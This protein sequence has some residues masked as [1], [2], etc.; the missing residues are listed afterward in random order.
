MVVNDYN[1]TM[2]VLERFRNSKT[3]S[4]AIVSSILLIDY[5]LLFAIVPVI[6]V[7]LW[8]HHQKSL[9]LSV[10]ISCNKS[11][12]DQSISAI[13]ITPFNHNNTI[14]DNESKNLSKQSMEN[15]YLKTQSVKIAAIIAAKPAVQVIANLLVGPLIDRI[16][17]SVPMFC[18]VIVICTTA[19]TFGM[20]QSY[21]VLLVSAAIQGIG[22]ACAMV[23]GMAMLMRKYTED[24]ERG[25]VIGL[26]LGAIGIG[27]IAGPPYGSVMNAF[28]GKATTFL[29]LGGIIAAIGIF[30]VF[31]NRLKIERKSESEKV[32]SLRKLLADPYIILAATSLMLV[33][34]GFGIFNSGLPAWLIQRFNSPKWM[35]GLAFIPVC[36]GYA[37]TTN[38]LSFIPM[39][40]M[41][42]LVALVGTYMSVAACLSLPFSTSFAATIGPTLILGIGYGLIEVNIYPIL[43]ILVD[44]RH[45]S[46]YGSVYAIADIS[47]CLGFIIGPL[48]TGSLLQLISFSWVLWMLTIVL[49]LFAPFLVFLKKPIQGKPDQETESLL[50]GSVSA[51]NVEE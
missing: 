4:V 34:I 25:K 20:G 40:N 19:T 45:K 35:L 13:T 8:K 36:I 2:S 46:D 23:G 37:V 50:N 18:G 11:K 33:N 5:L 7:F 14:E 24:E 48:L 31:Y 26:S 16:G 21:A 17:Y 43:A 6:P 44:T 32:T 38:V 1:L 51:K 3:T 15:A 9:N 30:Q 39:R 10:E 29:L 42:W 49:F 41:R 47:I 22:S 12:I 28:A 27:V